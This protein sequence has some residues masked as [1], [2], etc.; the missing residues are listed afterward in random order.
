[1]ERKH[2]PKATTP[3]QKL[4][5]KAKMKQAPQRSKASK[6]QEVFSAQKQRQSSSRKFFL[7]SI[8]LFQICS[9]SAPI[10]ASA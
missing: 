1:M 10:S 5:T 7:K 8:N 4:S 3:A 6:P 9:S 2:I